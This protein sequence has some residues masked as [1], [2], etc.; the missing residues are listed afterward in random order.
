MTA[1]SYDKWVGQQAAT[2]LCQ[3]RPLALAGRFDAAVYAFPSNG[4]EPGYLSVCEEQPEG[5]TD[6]VSFGLHGTRIMSVPCSALPSLL[7]QACRRLPI[8]PTV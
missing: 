8:C 4:S 6:C 1:F 3:I 2:I 7:W 5:A